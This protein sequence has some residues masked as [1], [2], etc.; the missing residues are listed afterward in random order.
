[1]T[2]MLWRS[3][4][5]MRFVSIL[6]LVICAS[7][8]TGK[9]APQGPSTSGKTAGEVF[10]NI[11]VLK[12]I[13]A[14][15]LIP[16]MQFISASLG[17]ECDF[18][19]VER[20]REKDD[21]KPKKIARQMMQMMLAIN[22]NNFSGERKVTCNTCHRGNQHPAAIPEIQSAMPQENG[23]QPIERDKVNVQVDKLDLANLPAGNPILADYFDTLG[24]QTELDKIQSRAEKGQASV[25]GHQFPIEILTQSPYQRL[26]VMR[27]PNGGSTTAYNGRVGW[28]ITPGGPVR[29][30]SSS[31]REGAKID[32]GIF[33]PT[34]LPALFDELKL[35]PDREIVSEHPTNV[36]LA[37]SK[38]QTVAKLYFDESSKL[39]V[40]VLRFTDT[41]LGLI[42]T[43]I[44]LSDYRS[45]GQIKTPFHWV[46]SRPNGTF[47]IQINDAQNNVPIDAAKF[48]EPALPPSGN[49]MP[50]SV[51]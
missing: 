3:N 46:I 2:K 33:F 17:V 28:L 31:D 4:A 8:V 11:Q 29:E 13:P 44:T 30:M 18:C 15:Q 41:A 10:K 24:G 19:H 5:V 20:E 9:S 7:S 12:T 32:A 22:A 47:E 48:T 16:T 1:M 50:S 49:S 42:P 35:Q 23:S 51:Q 39:L 14:D 40:R 25:N 26:S 37:V 21:K 27:L 6:L 36:L 38:G 34:K 43:E 45:V